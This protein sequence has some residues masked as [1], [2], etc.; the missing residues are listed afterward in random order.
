MN[1]RTGKRIV[2]ILAM[3]LIAVAITQTSLTAGSKAA[4][5]A[6]KPKANAEMLAVRTTIQQHLDGITEGNAKKL[7]AVWD[8][9]AQVRFIGKDKWGKDMVQVAPAKQLIKKWTAKPSPKNQGVIMSVDV[10]NNT[11]ASAKVSLTW[12]GTKL[13][14]YLTLMKTNGQ[15]RIVGKA[16]VAADTKAKSAFRYGA[17]D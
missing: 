8:A 12:N 14:D 11:M 6:S 5:K 9:H 15:W 7:E 10:V 3:T 13:I 2:T 4:V 16:F 1:S 17:P